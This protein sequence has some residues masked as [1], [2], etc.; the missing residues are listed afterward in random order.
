MFDQPTYPCPICLTPF[1]IE[2]LADKRLSA[3]HVPPKSVGGRELLLTCKGCNNSA[4]TKLDA[5]AKTK[6]D[7][8]I[9]LAGRLGRPHRRLVCARYPYE[10]WHTLNRPIDPAEALRGAG[11]PATAKTTRK[12]KGAKPESISCGKNNPC[13]SSNKNNPNCQG[14]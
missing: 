3:E 12:K 8:R 4:G 6:E 2:A 7:V 10:I 11:K 13:C 14:M 9:A 5:D 1:T